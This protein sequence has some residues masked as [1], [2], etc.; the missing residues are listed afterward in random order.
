MSLPLTVDLDENEALARRLLSILDKLEESPFVMQ[1]KLEAQEREDL[2][3]LR[4]LLE[5]IRDGGT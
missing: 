1:H 5:E 3:R 2:T 4:R